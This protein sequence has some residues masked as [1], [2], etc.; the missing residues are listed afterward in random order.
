MD[1]KT[2]ANLKPGETAQITVRVLDI[3]PLEFLI[4]EFGGLFRTP[5]LKKSAKQMELNEVTQ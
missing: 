2:L 4:V 1:N 3:S 5:V